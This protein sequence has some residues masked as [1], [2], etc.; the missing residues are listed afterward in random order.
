MD[1]C[2]IASG[3]R[4]EHYEM[5]AHG[6]LVAWAEAMGHSGSRRSDL[7]QGPAD[8]ESTSIKT[9]AQAIDGDRTL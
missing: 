5:A 2:L 9:I 3:Q 1:A 7:N 4:A 6:T 8:Y